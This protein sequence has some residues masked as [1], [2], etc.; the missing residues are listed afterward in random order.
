MSQ[1]LLPLFFDPKTTRILVLSGE[2][3]ALE[4][5]QTLLDLH[6]DLRFDVLA[7]SF[8]KDLEKLAAEQP[9]ITLL[10]KVL[11]QE[12][13]AG[14]DF[15]LLNNQ[16]TE[17]EQIKNLA[18]SL[19]L[20]VGEIENAHFFLSQQ[21]SSRTPN[22]P[23]VKAGRHIRRQ[24]TEK[25][26]YGRLA[27]QLSLLFLTFFVGYLFLTFFVGYG[28]SHLI[29]ADMLFDTFESVPSE[30]WGML[31]VGF[32]A[33]L[34]DGAIGLGY[35]VTC[36][37]SMM[38]LGIKLPAISGSI[39]TAEM[40]SSAIS[41]YSHYRFGNVNKKML[42][43]LASSGVVG[44]VSGAL[45]LVYLGNQFENLA[46]G[47][48][49]FY[50]MLIGLRLAAIALRKEI[51]K[52]KVKKIAILGFCGGFLDAFGGGGWGPIVSS[53]LLSKGRK[54]SYVVGTVS[55]SEFFVTFSASMVFFSALGI[56]HWH[57]ILG[58]IL[59]GALAAPLAAKLA[60]RVPQKVALLFV[61]FLV[62]VFSI[63]A[64]IKIW[65]SLSL[66]F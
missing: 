28:L 25:L 43:W 20:P 21:S 5:A 45:L 47:I 52:K 53:T 54:S 37:T 17:I 15:L 4:Q 9:R 13:L 64:F 10:K 66:S 31:L 11:A 38:L 24:S 50:T 35:G 55:L 42:Y 3:E 51:V 1:K 7:P 34:V 39:H 46:Y 40:F 8:C 49:A 12:D 18:K 22:L 59:G 2:K 62:M 32:F 19:N 30:F 41:G 33:Q 16:I 26:R 29:R 44:A 36:S 58:L 65:P 60:G 63:K 6:E 56:S 27:F 14:I 48:L 23:V 57:I 61:A